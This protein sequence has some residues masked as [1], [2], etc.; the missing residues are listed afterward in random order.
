[1]PAR[2]G[3]KKEYPSSRYVKDIKSADVW[4]VFKIIS[5][6]VQGYDELGELGPSVT[7]FGSARMDENHPYYVQ[8]RELAGMLAERG[9]NIIT[10][11]GPGIMEAANRGAYE[12]EEVESIGLNIELPSEQL[13][14]PYITKGRSFDYFFSRKVMLVR[15]SMAYV[16]FPGGFGTLDEM[17]EALTLIQTRKVWGVRLF[18]VGTEFFAP[19]M[20]FIRTK[21][22][23]EGMIDEADLNLI[24]LTDDL[25]FV[26]KE[27]EKSLVKQMVTLEEEGLDNTKYY[28]LLSTYMADRTAEEGTDI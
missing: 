4:S 6:F 20:E 21:L 12:Y 13:P 2:K 11:G 28:Q 14:N 24:I 22:I 1:M 5:D 10:G 9:Y 3:K 18:V 17:F 8:A 23:A 16:I 25:H 26:V 19:L 27:I 15:Y 7:I